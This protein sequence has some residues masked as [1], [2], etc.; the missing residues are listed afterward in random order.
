MNKPKQF[1]NSLVV[2]QLIHYCTLA[3]A[4][5]E[6]KFLDNIVVG[7]CNL[8]LGGNT[9]PLRLRTVYTILSTQ[10]IITTAVVMEAHQCSERHAQKIAACLR[11]ASKEFIK[12][13]NRLPNGHVYSAE[14]WSSVWK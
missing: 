7:V 6:F 9:R 8:D 13:L 4:S 1:D 12:H 2:E 10:P 11:I 5:E 3:E 14:N